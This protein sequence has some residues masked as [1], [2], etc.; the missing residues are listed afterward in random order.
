MI[1]G[2]VENEKC[3]FTLS[4]AKNIFEK[5]AHKTFGF[6][7]AHV[8]TKNLYIRKLSIYFSYQ[9]MDTKKKF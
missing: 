5:R 4:F 8:C 7:H 1:L 2:S 3:F 9:S 6:G